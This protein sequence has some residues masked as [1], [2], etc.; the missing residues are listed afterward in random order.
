[1]FSWEGN[2]TLS[3][4]ITIRFLTNYKLQD[5]SLTVIIDM[6]K[7]KPL[8]ENDSPFSLWGLIMGI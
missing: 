8:M 2:Q 5:V 6:V 7:R 1:M 3:E 4:Q